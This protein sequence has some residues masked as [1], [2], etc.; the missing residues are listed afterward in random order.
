M[1]TKSEWQALKRSATLHRAHLDQWWREMEQYKECL[2]TLLTNS[3]KEGSVV[4]SILMLADLHMATNI[5]ERQ[6]DEIEE[7]L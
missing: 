5:L 4:R 6:L 7:R 2:D 3:P 1:N